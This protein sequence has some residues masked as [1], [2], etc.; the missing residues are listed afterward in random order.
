MKKLFFHL[1]KMCLWAA[2]KD[3]D[4]LPVSSGQ[5]RLQQGGAGG[6]FGGA[7]LGYAGARGSIGLRGICRTDRQNSH[8]KKA[9]I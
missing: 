2:Q 7:W 1:V 4:E 8:K 3:I 5:P 6:A 9:N